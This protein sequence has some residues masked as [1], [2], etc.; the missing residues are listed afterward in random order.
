MKT[1]SIAI[2]AVCLLAMTLTA[3]STAHAATDQQVADLQAQLAAQQTMLDQVLKENEELVIENDRL[4]VA[5]ESLRQQNAKSGWVQVRRLRAQIRRL[6]PRFQSNAQRWAMITN[7]YAFMENGCVAG[8][9]YNTSTNTSGLYDNYSFS[10][11][12]VC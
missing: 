6:Q 12:G 2:A 3:P 10:R 11:W 7:L 8:W 4:V 5:N 9:E 1:S